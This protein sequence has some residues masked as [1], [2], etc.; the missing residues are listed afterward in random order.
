MAIS[1]KRI[2]IS[3]Y[4][5]VYSKLD[6]RLWSNIKINIILFVTGAQINVTKRKVEKLNFFLNVRVILLFFHIYIFFLIN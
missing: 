1:K 6:M 2:N 5:F 4:T 3:V